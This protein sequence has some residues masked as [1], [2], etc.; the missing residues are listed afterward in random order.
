MQNDVAYSEPHLVN[1]NKGGPSRKGDY[2][3]WD[4]DTVSSI[5]PLELFWNFCAKMSMPPTSPSPNYETNG[6][7]LLKLNDL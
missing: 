2:M 5:L 1:G 6:S 3:S 7:L 4:I